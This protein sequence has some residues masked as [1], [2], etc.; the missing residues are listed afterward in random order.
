MG[1]CSGDRAYRARAVPGDSAS[2][3]GKHAGDRHPPWT[4]G[5]VH[6]LSPHPTPGSLR[7]RPVDGNDLARLRVRGSGRRRPRPAAAGPGH[8]TPVGHRDSNPDPAE[9]RGMARALSLPGWL[10]TPSRSR[11]QPSSG[12]RRQPR[13]LPRGGSPGE[14]GRTGNAA[15]GRHTGG[16]PGGDAEPC[17]DRHLARPRSSRARPLG[18]AASS[19]LEA[20]ILC[21]V[22]HR[23]C[24]PG[25]GLG[26]TGRHPHRRAIPCSTLGGVR[27]AVRA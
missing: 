17:A 25:V 12:R 24:E 5:P 27:G 15:A 1:Q 11:S 20:Q 26:P 4:P 19:G 18:S 2:R 10:V 7:E 3:A 22:V 21:R 14:V 23:G 9:R 16:S 13:L 8:W 6:R